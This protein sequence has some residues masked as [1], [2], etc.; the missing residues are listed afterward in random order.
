MKL[1]LNSV[2]K[3]KVIEIQGRYDIQSIKEFEMIFNSQL[4]KKPTTLGIDMNQLEYIDSSGIGSL[5]KSLNVLKNQN[6]KLILFGL[7]P[8]VLNIFKQAKLD[9]FFDIMHIEEIRLK[10]MDDDED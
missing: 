5:I 6:G 3:L 7:K 8:M 4:E 10:Y 1:N 9:T 2:G